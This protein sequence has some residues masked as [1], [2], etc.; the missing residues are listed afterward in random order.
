MNARRIAALVRK[1]FV[2]IL[3][4]PSS[5]AIAFIMP[6]VLL[7]L[8][9]FAVTLDAKHV[10]IAIVVPNATAATDSLVGSFQD[11]AYFKPVVLRQRQPA[12]TALRRGEILAYV[13]LHEQ[14]EARLLRPSQP[15]LQVVVDG[16]DANTGRLI[17]GYVEQVWSQWLEL[18]ALQGERPGSG[19]LSVESRVWFN[20]EVRSENFLV[21]GLMAVIMTLTGALLTSLLVARE[22]DRGTIETLFVSPATRGEILLGKILPTFLLGLGGLAIS[23]AMAVTLFEVPLR[24]SLFIVFGAGALF[25]LATLGM[26]LLIS[27]TTKNQFVAGQLAIMTTF[28]PAFLLSG[29]IFNIAS[30]P[31]W[32]QALTYLVAARYLVEIFKTVFLVGDVW[33][34]V[35]PNA[36]ALALMAV[37]FLMLSRW[38]TRKRLE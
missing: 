6:L 27:T 28:L 26:G 23:V 29:F 21:P 4:D 36:A 33:S 2:Q 3:R 34:I 17:F 14:F 22:Y 35:L 10:R 24:G 7:F 11:N 15:P 19:G 31:E 32:V 12:E 30:M 16:S 25:L 8:F 1:E 9:G 18:R 37:G 20:P 13:A 38:R 5:L